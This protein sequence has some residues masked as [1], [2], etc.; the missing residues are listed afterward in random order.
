MQQIRA[1]SILKHNSMSNFFVVSGQHEI[2]FVVGQWVVSLRLLQ[3]IA[4]QLGTLR[5]ANA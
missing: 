2:I 5:D 1:F 4:R 3:N